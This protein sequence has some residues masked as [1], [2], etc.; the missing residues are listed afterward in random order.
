M[1]IISVY[2]QIY[3]WYN[4]TDSLIKFTFTKSKNC[5]L[6][7]KDLLQYQKYNIIY[8]SRY[9]TFNLCVVHYTWR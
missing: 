7:Y 4:V 5:D 8:V 9:A 6:I 3:K 1:W 2:I